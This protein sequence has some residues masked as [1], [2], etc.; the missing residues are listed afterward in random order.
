MKICSAILLLV[1]AAVCNIEQVSALRGNEVRASDLHTTE[2]ITKRRILKKGTEGKEPYE[3]VAA[4]EGGLFGAV[5]KVA[6]KAKDKQETVTASAIAAANST[7]N[8]TSVP[9]FVSCKY[10]DKLSQR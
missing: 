1:A 7:S 9:T 5:K 3:I 4:H 10:D 6:K 2:R 8:A